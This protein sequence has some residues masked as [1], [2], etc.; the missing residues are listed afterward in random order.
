MGQRPAGRARGH[1]AAC[2][3]L[4]FILPKGQLFPSCSCSSGLLLSSS[5]QVPPPAWGLEIPL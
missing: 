3:C 5:G 2:W 1:L 4:L